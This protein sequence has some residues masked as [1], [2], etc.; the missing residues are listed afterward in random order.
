M[1]ASEHSA[2]I[3]ALRKLLPGKSL[4]TE[5]AELSPFEMDGLMMYRCR[6]LAVAI[7]DDE[8]QIVAVIKACR[9]HGLTVVTRGAGTGL[10]GGATPNERGISLVTSRLNQIVHIDPLARVATVQPG[11]RNL[12]VSEAARRYGLMYAPDPSSQVACSVGGNVAENSGGVRCLKYGLTVQNVERLRAVT[13]DGDV[14]EVG[15]PQWQ[16]YDFLALLHGSE[17]LLAVITEITV[18]LTPIP[19]ATRTLLAAFDDIGKGR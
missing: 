11:V 14:I 8:A 5:Q 17:G 7:P 4:L 1:G 19:A 16:G 3:A 12:A 6:P 18:R 13:V 9:Q 2:G 15:G 10:S